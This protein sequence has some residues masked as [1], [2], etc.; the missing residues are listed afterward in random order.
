MQT[1]K[2]YEMAD[3]LGISINS[4]TLPLTASMSVMDADGDCFIGIDPAQIE[5]DAD[6]KTKI[7]HEMGHCVTGSFYSRFILL[8]LRER[9]EF[10]ADVWAV[11]ELVP[12]DDLNAAFQRGCTELWELAEE[13][14]VAEDFIK[15]ALD[16]Y[17]RKGLY[18]R[19]QSEL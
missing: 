13:F 7:A 4:F 6:E 14:G 5:N 11:E 2:I 12:I 1:K 8:D 16:I 15:R 19:P 10:R 3:E 9:H 18:T 17:E